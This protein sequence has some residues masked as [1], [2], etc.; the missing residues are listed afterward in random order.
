MAKNV[1]YFEQF[2]KGKSKKLK[3]HAKKQGYKV[4]EVRLSNS[5]VRDLINPQV[6]SQTV[7]HRARMHQWID[8]Y[9]SDDDVALIK[10]QSLKLVADRIVDDLPKHQR[11]NL[12]Y[13]HDCNPWAGKVIYISLEQ[14]AICHDDLYQYTQVVHEDET[15]TVEF[16]DVKWIIDR[17]KRHGDKVDPYILPQPNGEHSLGLRYGPGESEYLSPPCNK[18][19]AQRLI[20]SA[21][22]KLL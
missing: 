9:I 21:R 10:E 6:V 8:K 13:W 16:M 4:K 5:D 7:L 22:R 3:K 1:K 12:L 11:G 19:I 20:D 18:V 17:A 14:W 15:F 2:G